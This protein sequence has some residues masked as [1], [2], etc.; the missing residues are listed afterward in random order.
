MCNCICI[1]I[2]TD[3]VEVCKHWTHTHTHTEICV[4]I[5]I[6]VCVHVCARMTYSVTQPYMYVVIYDSLWHDSFVI[7]L[8]RKCS[9]SLKTSQ[10][11]L[12]RMQV[13]LR[14]WHGANKASNFD[15]FG[16]QRKPAHALQ[17]LKLRPVPWRSAIIN[18][19][20]L[21][22]ITFAYIYIYTHTHI[23]IYIYTYV[24]VYI[25]IYF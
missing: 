7:D 10:E 13:L 23:Y 24:Y 17:R 15:G 9:E 18:S 6:C 25:Y 5:H 19:L 16:C 12:M 3:V 20:Y 4:H 21:W 11:E 1:Y 14:Q 8:L 2:Y 22:Y